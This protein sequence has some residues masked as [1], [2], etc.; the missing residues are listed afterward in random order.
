MRTPPVILDCGA[1]SLDL[2]VPVIMGI[3]NTTPDS[4]SDGGLFSAVDAAVE[5]G[6]AMVD[7]GAALIDVGGESTRPGATPVP[8][9]EEIERV[10]PVIEKLASRV[11]TP[12]SIDTSKPEVMTAAARVGAGM[13]NDVRAL[14]EPGAVE[15]AAASGLPVCLM[16]MAGEPRSMQAKPRYDDIVGEILAF[17]ES[18]IEVC[19]S[20]GIPRQRLLI[21]PGF[22]FGK[23]LRHNLCLLANLKQFKQFKLP[24]LVGLSRKSMFGALLDADLDQRM[25]ASIAAALLA[26]QNGADIIRVHDV[27]ETDQAL[28]LYEAVK[29]I[30]AV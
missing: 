3:L 14:R 16:H 7:A 15:A 12:I 24:L 1:R 22:G 9:D 5:H 6:L 29:E 23:S 25:P 8:V 28:R 20:A 2:S 19:I 4:F 21:D 17:F 18:R 30:N 13:I 26:R 11:E 10:I 27:G